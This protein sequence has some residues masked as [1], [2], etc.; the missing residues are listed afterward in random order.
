MGLTAAKP[1][2]GVSSDL[3]TVMSK[4]LI[5]ASLPFIGTEKA[6]S[7][8]LKDTIKLKIIIKY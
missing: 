7:F 6:K 3:R 5:V 2:L 4:K 1:F 8:N